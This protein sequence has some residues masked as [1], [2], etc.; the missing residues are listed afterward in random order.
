MVLKR[1]PFTEV[2]YLHRDRW[3]ETDPS[4]GAEPA[5]TGLV[6]GLIGQNHQ[7]DSPSSAARQLAAL[8]DG[9]ELRLAFPLRGSHVI[10]EPG[11]GR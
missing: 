7:P 5:R 3:R 1:P 9:L 4:G 8:P 2:W 6:A 10:I 11:E